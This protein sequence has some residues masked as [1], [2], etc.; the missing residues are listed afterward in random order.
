MDHLCLPALGG[1]GLAVFFFFFPSG[2]SGEAAGE[3][4]N[5]QVATELAQGVAATAGGDILPGSLAAA[6]PARRRH[7]PAGPPLLASPRAG[8]ARLP[9]TLS[10]RLRAARGAARRW[11]PEPGAAAAR[12]RAG[13]PT[14]VAARG[15]APG[16]GARTCAARGRGAVI[17]VPLTAGARPA[18]WT[19][20]RG[21][22]MGVV[23][24]SRR[25]A[26]RPDSPPPRIWSHSVP[27]SPL[28]QPL[29]PPP[30]GTPSLAPAPCL[31]L[32]PQAWRRPA[33]A[34]VGRADPS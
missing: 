7:A 30:S 27:R 23:A 13:D 8:G 20:R 15:R 11:M 16:M 32:R 33:R 6:A 3:G 24:G 29:L 21:L 2:G 1:E 22:L 17:R 31:S 19:L 25:P 28:P 5:Y 9:P 4:S 34:A 10:A 12:T 26:S 14:A 18:G